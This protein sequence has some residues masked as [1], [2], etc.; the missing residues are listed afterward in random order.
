[1]DNFPYVA[2]WVELLVARLC[3]SVL[4]IFFPAEDSQFYRATIMGCGASNVKNVHKTVH[5]KLPDG[6]LVSVS[7]NDAHDNSFTLYFVC[8]LL[9]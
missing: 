8:I 2:E 7:V 5:C 4:L 3:Q 6:K 1:M 9:S